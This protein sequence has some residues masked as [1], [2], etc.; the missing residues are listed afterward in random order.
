[1]SRGFRLGVL[2]MP[3]HRGGAWR[4]ALKTCSRSGGWSLAKVE[5]ETLAGV[6]DSRG[7]VLLLKDGAQALALAAELDEVV[8]ISEPLSV[9][10]DALGALYPG[11]ASKAYAVAAERLAAATTLQRMGCV[12]VEGEG[13]KV[14]LPF[15]GVVVRNEVDTPDVPSLDPS[16]LAIY[17]NNG[18]NVGQITSWEWSVFNYKTTSRSVAVPPHIDLTGRSRVIFHGPRFYMPAGEWT[19]AL[20]FWLNPEGRSSLLKFEWGARED[21]EVLELQLGEVGDYEVELSKR[22]DRIGAL[23]LRAWVSS[24][25]FLGEMTVSGATLIYTAD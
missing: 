7:V 20:R 9:I 14:D 10:C 16:P 11:K 8:V 2:Q 19:V 25:H 4:A 3:S 23:E 15:I 13:L 24:G 5:G 21:F 22:I 6:D 12:V 1:M 17:A 18:P